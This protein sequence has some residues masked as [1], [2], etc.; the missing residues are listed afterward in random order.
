MKQQHS[1]NRSIHLFNTILIKTPAGFFAVVKLI[2]KFTWKF[3]GPRIAKMIFEKNKVGGLTFPNF[4]AYYG[5]IAAKTVQYSHRDRHID[6]WNR[7]EN[8]EIIHYIQS[9]FHKKPKNSL[10]NKWCSENYLST[11]KKKKSKLNLFLTL[12]IN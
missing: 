9:I 5:A 10:F 3:K 4:E 8:T 7:I 6:L 11:L 1:S 12:H 2:L